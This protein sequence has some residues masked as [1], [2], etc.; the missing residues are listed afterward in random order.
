[1]WYI[2]FRAPLCYYF[3]VCYFKN[4]LRL[5]LLA[6]L[7]AYLKISV[8]V[9]LL[10]PVG[11]FQ[12]S[13]SS[14]RSALHCFASLWRHRKSICTSTEQNTESKNPAYQKT[15][16]DAHTFLIFFFSVG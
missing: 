9:K 5:Y 8:H 1:M 10:C 4:F 15:T 6:Y 11:R 16:T 14:L 3:L 12:C 7:L 2:Q 13:A